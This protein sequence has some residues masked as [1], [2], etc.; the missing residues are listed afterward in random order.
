MFFY[1]NCVDLVL[2]AFLDSQYICFFI[3]LLWVLINKRYCSSL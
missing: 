2:V 1:I 3:A